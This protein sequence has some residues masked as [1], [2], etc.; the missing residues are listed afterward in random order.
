MKF[1]E[2]AGEKKAESKAFCGKWESKQS[3][4]HVSP[5]ERNKDAFINVNLSTKIGSSL[6]SLGENNWWYLVKL[7]G[8]YL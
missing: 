7:L 8:F 1:L 2:E 4:K 5:C 6:F 3:R